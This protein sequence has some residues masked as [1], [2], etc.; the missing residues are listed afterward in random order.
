L[1][2]VTGDKLFSELKMSFAAVAAREE[3]SVLPEGEANEV[4]KRLSSLALKTNVA[5]VTLTDPEQSS[6][7]TPYYRNSRRQL[8]SVFLNCPPELQA[9]QDLN[10]ILAHKLSVGFIQRND[11]EVYKKNPTRVFVDIGN[12]EQIRRF[13]AEMTFLLQIAEGIDYDLSHLKSYSDITKGVLK[14]VQVL[15]NNARGNLNIA[16]T[17]GQHEVL[18]NITQVRSDRLGYRAL[19]QTIVLLCDHLISKREGQI[20]KRLIDIFTGKVQ[21]VPI[22]RNVMDITNIEPLY[23]WSCV[24]SLTERTM[25]EKI[26]GRNIFQE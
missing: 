11:Y 4:I 2:L 18:Q 6:K 26:I 22:N 3:S 20:S 17:P 7:E 12:M 10:M 21:S 9:I 16:M 1:N 15:V 19:M 14:L 24:M 25:V 5:E 23:I 8:F 13:V